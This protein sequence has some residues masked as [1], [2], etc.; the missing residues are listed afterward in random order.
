MQ[1]KLNNRAEEIK[2][3]IRENFARFVSCKD[4]IDSVRDTLVTNESGSSGTSAIV[5][6]T[7]HEIQDHLDDIFKAMLIRKA[8]VDP[9]LSPYT[10]Y[11]FLSQCDKIR[12]QLKVIQSYQFIFSMP[13]RIKKNIEQAS[14]LHL[15]SYI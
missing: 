15:F 9:K 14:F 3:L 7:Y 12:K 8:E 13:A 6:K 4:I 11:T 1:K 2:R 10:F 5:D